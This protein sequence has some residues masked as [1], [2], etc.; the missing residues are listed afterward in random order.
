MRAFFAEEKIKKSGGGK[1][2][3]LSMEALFQAGC[4]GC[5]LN[6]V[7]GLRHPKMDATGSKR[8]LV[9]MLGEAPGENED[10][11]GKQF[12][13]KAG[14]LLRKYIDTDVKYRWNNAINC[15]PG[16][17]NPNPT[18]A[19]LACCRPR[20][21][22]DIERTKPKAIFGFGGV[23]LKW[24]LDEDR[25]G[26]W[27]GRRIP[28]KIGE[29]SC[30][31]YPFHHPSFLARGQK[32]HYRTGNLMPGENE[33]FF[34]R[35]LD[36]AFDELEDLPEAYVVEDDEIRGGVELI[37]SSRGWKDVKRIKSK[38]LQYAKLEDVAYDYETASDEPDDKDRRTRPYGKNARILSVAVGT[39]NDTIAF[40][41]RHREA[42]W[43][44]QQLSA[45]EKAWSEFLFSKARKAA[46]NL[47]FE[48]EWS[49]FFYGLETA[50]AC[51]WHDTM[52]QAYV[53]GHERGTLSLDALTLI[54][55]GFRLK[56]KCN[57]NVSELD[58]EPIGKV[59][60]YNALDAK[61]THALFREQLVKIEA[62]SLDNVYDDQVRRTPGIVLKSYFGMLIDFD[63]VVDFDKNY[64]PRIE[65]HE[66]WF[67]NSKAV[68]KY[69]ARFGK[70]FKPSSP[71]DV[72]KLFVNVLGRKECKIKSKAQGDNEDKYSTE[73]KV[74]EQIDHPAAKR[75]QDYRAVRG[76]KSKYVDP[77]LPKGYKP[78]TIAGKREEVGRC[79]WPDGLTHAT[80]HHQFIVSR[81]TS[82]SFP[83]EQFWPKRDE[84]FT[85][86]R[87]M[88]AAP[89][90]KLIRKLASSFNYSFPSH[91]N[92]DDCY[93][94]TIDYGQIQAR[95]AG[96]LSKDRLYCTYLWDR[97]DLH[98]EWTKNL[99]RA[100]PRRIGGKKF[101][102]DTTALKKFRLDVKNQWTFPL[103]FG[104]TLRSVAGY[105]GIPEEILKPL[106]QQFFREMPGLAK[107]QKRMRKFYDENGYVEGPTGWRRYGPLDHGEVINTPI[108]NGEAEIVLDA[109]TRLSEAAQ[110]LDMW[111]FQTRLEVH[112][113]LGFWL[114]KK[115]IDRDLEF[116]A[117]H[118][119]ECEH[120]DW[121]NVPLLIE[122][123]RGPNWFDQS[124][125]TEIFSDD[126]GKIDRKE[127]GF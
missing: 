22:E 70:K 88:F 109:M 126:I 58:N 27:R 77:L 75:M 11:R 111:Q 55:F 6:K 94:V 25:I 107:W 71:Q 17:G 42:Q 74:L 87:K 63:S 69:E 26:K 34:E 45:V 60:E 76:N 127:C 36:R 49:I 119:L 73:D 4:T 46:H 101:L 15:W 82:C 116:V 39:E 65:G 118:M 105:L 80:L 35:D 121:I 103:I 44:K 21:I 98:M 99:A 20:L 57:V 86:L 38:L 9:Y 32:K 112:D 120:F 3:Q 12:I 23:P 123:S 13:G 110:E 104:A 30:W 40:P 68:A 50:R 43:T 122:I 28:V 96:M 29:H 2:T 31:F 56:D 33:K 48:L 37:D 10:K 79:I 89:T 54:N 97:N 67:E 84:N 59:L 91:L 102:K 51:Q 113:E 115:T 53:L 108:Q 114:P 66:E 14:Q 62:E 81:R 117:D 18:S 92:E 125:N 93:F 106:I 124:D 1:Q 83:N 7:K 8:P 52:S 19:Q 5:P 85:D 95:I 78:D 64:G 47:F 24:A 90:K 100:Y 72:K 16:K 61:W 41:L